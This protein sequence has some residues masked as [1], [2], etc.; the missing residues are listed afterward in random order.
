[1]LTAVYHTIPLLTI[2]IPYHT[3]PYPYLPLG[4]SRWIRFLIHKDID[5]EQRESES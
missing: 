3:I 4:K 1:M 2:T 5:I